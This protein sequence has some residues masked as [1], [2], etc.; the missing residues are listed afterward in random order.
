MENW[1][2]RVI[3]R[4]SSQVLSDVMES[5][6][7]AIYVDDSYK[8]NGVQTFFDNHLKPFYDHHIRLQ[9]LSD[10]PNKTLTEIL[11]A[12]SCQNH[13]IVKEMIGTTLPCA[14]GSALL[15]DCAFS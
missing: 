9:T 3:N 15:I 6:I 11:H 14:G 5:I 8:N 1:E 10:H 12:E 7:G 2:A 13:S 4:L